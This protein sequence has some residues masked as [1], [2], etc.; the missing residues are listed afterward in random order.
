MRTTIVLA[1]HGRTAWHHGNRYTGSSDLP[2]D[3]VGQQQ[4]LPAS[5]HARPRLPAAQP[6]AVDHRARL[7]WIA[8]HTSCLAAVIRTADCRQRPARLELARNPTWS[9]RKFPR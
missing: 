7:F 4:A 5:Q 3:E 6:L 8:C 1:R 9:R 2:I